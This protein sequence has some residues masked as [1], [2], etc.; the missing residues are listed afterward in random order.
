[1]ASTEH[2]TKEQKDFISANL[3]KISDN[4]I[5]KKLGLSPRDVQYYR[6]QLES[7][8]APL[9]AAGADPSGKKDLFTAIFRKAAGK[10]ITIVLF[11]AIIALSFFLRRHTFNLPHFRGDQ[12]HY[13]GLAFKLDTKGMAGYNLRGIDMLTVRQ[14]PQLIRLAPA[15]DKGRILKGLEQ[16]NITYYDQ[17][18]HHIPYGFPVAIMLSHKIFAAKAPYFML[19]INDSQV[20]RQAPRGVGLR[21]FRFDPAVAGKQFYSI[22]IPLAFSLLL[23]A[24]TFF[25]ARQ[26]F[27]NDHIALIAMF[28]MAV[29]PI[30]ILTSQKLWA[31]DMTAALSLLA[32]LL[33]ILSVNKDKPGLAI[34]SGI[35]CGLSAITK[36]SGAFIVIVIGIWHFTSN[37]DRLF[38]KETFLETVFDKKLWLFGLGVFIG[39]GYWFLKVMDVYGNPFYRPHQTNIAEIA[40]TPWF[41]MV[42]SRPWYI[43]L[44]GI[45]YQNP[46][47]ALAY[48]S[49]LWMWLEKKNWKATLL[50][51]IWIAVFLYIFQVYLGGGGKE[52]RY[53]LPAYPAFAILGAYVANRLRIYLDNK[54]GH[55]TGTVALLI[56]LLA[57]ALWSIPMGLDVLF[58]NGALIMKPF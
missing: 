5:A 9:T 23:I 31:D 28:L 55:H 27:K 2:L 8:G 50:P 40:K 20:I 39:A 58:M 26:L 18:L 29:S 15:K 48:I 52:Q 25:L 38:R 13:V 54:V 43:Y 37:L 32:V 3:G 47:F 4:L 33:Y 10:K 34:V 1:M 7:G 14:Y 56:A 44:I 49:P 21:N 46:V 51:V 53:M 57:A 45:P 30:D 12:H 17:P 36:Q 35:C 11:C 24:L 22:I 6:G 19:A 41:K 16:A 42:G